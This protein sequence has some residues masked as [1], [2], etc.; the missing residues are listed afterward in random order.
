MKAFTSEVNGNLSPSTLMES[1][2]VYFFHFIF[3]YNIIQFPYLV[4]FVDLQRAVGLIDWII[5]VL[6]QSLLL[7]QNMGG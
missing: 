1:V 4:L 3:F 5:P 6:A 2:T 7:D